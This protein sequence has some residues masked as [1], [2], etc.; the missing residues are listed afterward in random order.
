MSDK[1]LPVR[2]TTIVKNT[3]KPVQPYRLCAQLFFAG[4][5]LWIGIEF[6]QF[7]HHLEYYQPGAEYYRPPGVEAFL[8]ISSLMS[9]LY[10]LQTGQVHPVH[11]AGF[12]LFIGIIGLSLFAGKSFC[13][14]VCPI[15]FLSEYAGEFG[16]KLFRGKLS[17]PKL[18]D[19]PFRGLKYLLLGFFVFSVISMSVV[20]LRLFLSGDYNTIADIKLFEFFRNMT[21]IAFYTILSLLVLSVLFRNFWCRYLCPYGAFL[22]IVGLLS[23]NK[24]T[25]NEK[26]C[27]DCSLCDK[28][29]PSGIGVS[30]SK[31]V[32]SDECTSC[33]QCIDVCPV[34]DALGFRVAFTKIRI[35]KQSVAAG[36]LILFLLIIAAGMVSGN[37]NNHIPSATYKA[38]Y[39]NRQSVS[40]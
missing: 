39:E 30:G 18:L 28:A 35:Q 31:V 25:R 24:I 13:S 22:G 29:C 5:C 36:L 1:R 7:I 11:P 4:A 2:K 3:R 27:V 8:P 23:P 10:F 19:I 21:P 37:W 15:G 14:W 34:K 20:E 38:I 33:M 12:F 17:L 6:I 32:V 40:H 9:L 16:R 26:S